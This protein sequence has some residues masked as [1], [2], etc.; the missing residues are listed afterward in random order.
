[1]SVIKTFAPE[2]ENARR[3]TLMIRGV[4]LRGLFLARHGTDLL[5]HAHQIVEQVFFHNLAVFVPARDGTEINVEALARGL[6]HGSIR[7]RHWTF[8]GSSEISDS[9]RLFALR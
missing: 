1:M 7:H 2:A 8:H 9:P 5:Q 4:V 6:N 3:G